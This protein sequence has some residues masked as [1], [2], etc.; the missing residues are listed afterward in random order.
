MDQGVD[1]RCQETRKEERK[2]KSESR[3]CGEKPD[4]EGP[5]DKRKFKTRWLGRTKEERNE[6]ETDEK[7]PSIRRTLW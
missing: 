7:S 5:I 6:R 3:A 1:S 2:L 4:F